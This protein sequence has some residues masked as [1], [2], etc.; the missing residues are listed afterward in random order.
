MVL[1]ELGTALAG[2]LKKL[3]EHTV[4][5]EEIMEACLKEVTRALLQADVNVQYV[6]KMKAHK[7]ENV[8]A[9]GERIEKWQS[10]RG[11][12]EGP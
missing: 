1:G 2:A 7:C 12:L 3:G 5:D 9:E 6:V 10:E 11:A 8:R 4:V